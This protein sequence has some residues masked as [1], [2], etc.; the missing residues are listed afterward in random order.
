MIKVTQLNLYIQWI[1]VVIKD[2]LSF[3]TVIF[4][5]FNTYAAYFMMLTIHKFRLNLLFVS[6][7]F[8]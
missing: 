6:L 2:C 4:I 5:L 7:D 8:P 3:E 1:D